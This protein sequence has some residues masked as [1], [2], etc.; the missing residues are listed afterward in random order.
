MLNI[1]TG[2]YVFDYLDLIGLPREK[3]AVFPKVV[4][5][6]EVVGH[7]GSG[8]FLSCG[9]P[10]GLPVIAGAL[11]VAAATF[12]SG[13]RQVGDAVSILGTTLSNQVII[14]ASQVSHEDVAGSTLCF[15]TPHTFMRVLATSNGAGTIDWA[16]ETLAPGKSYHD[17]ETVL[18]KTIPV[19]SEGLFF[20]PYLNGERAP[21]RDARATASFAGLGLQHNTMHMLRAV[22]EGLAYGMRDCHTHLPQEETPINL[23]GG[24]SKSSFLSQLCA[25]VLGRP[26]RS[27]PKQ[28]FGLLG[29]AMAWMTGM[30]MPLPEAV[31]TTESKL[32][33][34]RKDL[35]AIYDEGYT[36]FKELR[37]ASQPF[38]QQRDAFLTHRN[39]D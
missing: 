3:A 12:G 23:C 37:R 33:S 35:T 29:M 32:Y 15:I 7:T 11:D 8:A 25:D 13:A 31:N 1:L 36:V 21:F 27:I 6:T 16:I 18:T 2:E 10:V 20:L 4:D 24:A 14:D 9:L 30:G 26:T 5:S 39:Q 38:W 28:E 34:P 19:G 22:Y 17:L